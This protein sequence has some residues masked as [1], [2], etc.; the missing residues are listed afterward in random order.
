MRKMQDKLMISFVPKQIGGR[1]GCRD[2]GQ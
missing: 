1:T 2:R